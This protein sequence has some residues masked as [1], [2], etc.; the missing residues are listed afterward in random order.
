MRKIE[1]ILLLLVSTLALNVVNA[2]QMPMFTN[3]G[4]S[5]SVI[6][7]GFFG[8]CEG[9]NANGIYRNQWTGFKDGI[10]GEVVS[11]RTFLVSADLP[12]KALA[13]GIGISILKDQVGFENSVGVNLGYSYHLDLA[14]GTLGLGLSMS[15]NNRNVD[16]SNANA[17]NQNDPA[18]PSGQQSDML[19]DVNVGLFYLVPET[20]YVALSGT[21]LL[22]SKGKALDGNATSSA[23]FTG[24]R[25]LFL[26]AG[27][28]YQFADPRFMLN[29]SL[30][31]MTNFASSQFNVTARLWYNNKLNLGVNY[32]YQES[33]DILFGFKFKE[34]MITY[35]YD[36]NTMGISVPGS[37]EVSVSYCFKLDMDKS[38]RIY[39]SIRYL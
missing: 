10:T 14:A 5:Y 37:H 2:Q 22:E 24:D 18:I 38:P 8:M 28:E 35:A 3:Y 29:P 11:P 26:V 33:V 25:T 12:L 9:V 7:P 32:R 31:A 15:L 13:G 4:N 19:F 23:C 6:N 21:N 30:C 34:I 27:Y 1:K 16:F 20:F 17:L 39:R 36:I